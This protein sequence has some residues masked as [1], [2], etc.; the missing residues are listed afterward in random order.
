MI[1]IP[2]ATTNPSLV[3]AAVSKPEYSHLVDEAVAYALRTI[4]SAT[5]E[6]KAEL[7]SD[8]LVSLTF[9][10]SSRSSFVPLF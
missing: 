8:R 6:E 2:D 3:Y 7:A 10:I 4:P 9:F 1:C 5:L